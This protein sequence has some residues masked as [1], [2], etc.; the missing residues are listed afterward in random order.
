MLAVRGD[1]RCP[2]ASSASGGD[3]PRPPP[4]GSSGWVVGG[5]VA[6]G[7]SDW[8]W[9]ADGLLLHTFAIAVPATMATAVLLDLVA[10][11]GSLA[12][13]E[14]AGLVVAPTAACARSGAASR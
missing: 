4:P 1:D 5:I 14:R 11:P 7:L 3:G 10:R 8:D 13:G 2:C 9:G 12:M 6:L